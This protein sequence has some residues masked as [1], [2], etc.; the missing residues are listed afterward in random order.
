[1]LLY[2]FLSFLFVLGISFR[3]IRTIQI[4][5][6]GDDAAFYWQTA[7]EWLHGNKELSEHFRP[8]IY[9]LN[10]QIM[11]LT[12][13]NDW[14]LRVANGVWDSL[15][16][17]M[18]VYLGWVLR[19]NW[20]L[21]LCF[22]VSYLFLLEPLIIARSGL[23]HS[24]STFFLICSVASLLLWAQNKKMRLL[25]LSGLFMSMSW[26]IH[27]D[28]AVLG[29]SVTLVILYKNL[30][31]QG[32]DSTT[33]WSIS[34]KEFLLFVFGYFFVFFVFAWDLGFADLFNNF[35][36]NFKTQSKSLQH[37]LSWRFY[38]FSSTYLIANLGC[39]VLVLLG[40]ATGLGVH[41]IIKKRFS[42][43]DFTLFIFPLGFLFFCALLFAQNVITRLLLPL[44]P[45]MMVFI[46]LQFHD[47]FRGKR[48]QT[49]VAPVLCLFIFVFN[50]DS[51]RYPFHE[52]VSVYKEIDAHF[53]KFLKKDSILLITPLSIL[54]IHAPLGKKM[55][56]DG[57]GKYLVSTQHRSLDETLSNEKVTH[58]WI[59]DILYDQRVFGYNLKFTYEERLLTLYGLKPSEYTLEKEKQM[60]RDFLLTKKAV[61]IDRSAMGELYELK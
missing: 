12:G 25:F 10:A 35:L 13:P 22:A 26:L 8:F 48:F 40:A 24:P 42:T 41:K 16:A 27:P 1:M 36:L 11:G 50:I 21:G 29:A 20:L 49:L 52:P 19:R 17:V 38:H 2:I 5:A 9:W 32:I 43:Q 14:I 33:F 37:G 61:L 34:L 56:L 18:L 39:G 23:V 59:A 31:H 55:Y 45:V 51:F 3:F 4:G 47:F 54:H 15:T 30:R 53:Q 58:V 44:V 46:V 6:G 57:R 28:L 7:Y 60:L